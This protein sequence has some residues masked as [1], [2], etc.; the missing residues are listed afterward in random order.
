MTKPSK[1]PQASASKP[2]FKDASKPGYTEAHWSMMLVPNPYIQ[3]PNANNIMKIPLT[4]PSEIP[5]AIALNR[6][7]LHL[8]PIKHLLKFLG[9][10]GEITSAMT[11]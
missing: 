10:R 2:P 3:L 1:N 11:L 4:K 6:P 9:E 8:L 5:N 7:H